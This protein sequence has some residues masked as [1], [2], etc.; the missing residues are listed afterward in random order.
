MKT[1]NSFLLLILASTYVLGNAELKKIAYYNS[2]LPQ[3]IELRK[4]VLTTICCKDCG[5]LPK[6]EHA[7]EIVTE[8]SQ[9]YQLMHNG[10]KV[11]KDCY[12]G[13][14]MTTLIQLLHGHHEP[15]EEKIFHE[16]LKYIPRNSIMIEL[17]S[18]W[19]YYSMWFQ[20]KI[21]GARNFLIEPDPKNILIGKKH[22]ELNNM[23]G[24]FMQAMVGAT[25]NERQLFTD[26][27]YN[28]HEIEMICMD[29]FA[30]KNNVD[31]IYL[32]H[33]DIQGAEIDML[34]GCQQLIAQKRIGYF[35]V[36]THRGTHEEC[37]KILTEAHLHIVLAHT[38]KESFSADGLIVAKLPEILGPESLDVS[39]RTAE[40]C[41]MVKKVNHENQN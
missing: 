28:N 40:F 38:R 39:L 8:Q 9:E 37:L 18:Y 33:S 31:F 3:D 17:G 36:S 12:Y 7:G 22:F 4:R 41:T 2:L 24:Y 14:W 6:V 13:A 21:M 20:Q 35:F 11:L 5:Y 10:I 15:Q 16:I 19:G 30:E 32:L 27:D 1:R 23:H 25:S 26:W 34:K 29:D